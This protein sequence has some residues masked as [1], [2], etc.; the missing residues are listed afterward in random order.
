MLAVI[1][2]KVAQ[3]QKFLQD[4]TRIPVTIVA[5]PGNT[6]MMH[7][8]QDTDGYSA[9]QLGFG[10]RK[11]ANKPQLG[12]AKKA[13]LQKAPLFMA[14]ARLT[15]K[16]TANLPEVGTLLTADTVLAAGDM[17]DV[18]GVS[19]GKGFA[20]GVKRYQFRGGPKTHGQS[21]R[22]RA[23]GSIGSGTTPG[24]VYRGKRMAGKMGNDTTTLKNLEIV[25]VGKDYIWVKGLIPG[26]IGAV[27]VVRTTG[28]KNK[29]FVEPLKTEEELKEIAAADAKAKEEAEK[30]AQEAAKAAEEEASSDAKAMDDKK[31]SPDASSDAQTM[32]D[33][34]VQPEAKEEAQ[35]APKE[36]VKAEEVKEE[37][38]E[39]T[40]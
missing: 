11:H 13:Q 20:G 23:P 4:G 8:T 2:K 18:S 19:K 9:L 21:D 38:K 1:G 3:T 25:K 33:K 29:K 32:D 22:H 35:E 26:V 24:R 30:Q 28:K 12:H 31:E 7:K 39:E 14:E 16:E 10:E 37:V 5:T 40:K 36:E 27:V 34:E 17:V 15:D 6:V